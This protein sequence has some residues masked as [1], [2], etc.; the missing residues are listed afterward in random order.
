[1]NGRSW[2]VE[3]A[4]WSST[5]GRNWMLSANEDICP[6]TLF[7]Q[8]LQ[9][10]QE[11]RYH[12]YEL[13][14]SFVFG[15]WG[16]LAM[17][18]ATQFFALLLHL[19]R[20]MVE[21]QSQDSPG[22]KEKMILRVLGI[23]CSFT[24]LRKLYYFQR[25]SSKLKV[26]EGNV[27]AVS[28]YFNV[29]LLQISMAYL[30][31]RF[32]THEGCEAN[33]FRCP[34]FLTSPHSL[35]TGLAVDVGFLFHLTPFSPFSW[36]VLSVMCCFCVR[37]LS[38]F[39]STQPLGASAWSLACVGVAKCIFLALKSHRQNSNRKKHLINNQIRQLKSELVRLLDTMIP[40]SF[41]SRA[42]TE[43]FIAD[44]Y[45]DATV[46]FCSC[47]FHDDGTATD[48]LARF[49][50]VKMSTS[51]IV[52]ELRSS[53]IRDKSSMHIINRIISMMNKSI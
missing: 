49:A 15:K 28:W 38:L 39:F 46:L 16:S 2:V 4:G 18:F 26:V 36:L 41:S 47:T 21:Y 20:E 23:I 13:F 3:S 32:P 9:L 35:C 44:P 37:A 6:F 33:R 51:P 50:Q 48:D 7:F 30:A 27:L 34:A 12:Y 8:D 24:C 5:V 42:K 22:L 1:L 43:P 11:Y 17:A 53:S 31:S 45:D 19:V 25:L 29:L 10:E 14:G 52:I 40:P